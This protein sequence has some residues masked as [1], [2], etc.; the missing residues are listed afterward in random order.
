MYGAAYEALAMCGV[1]VKLN[2]EVMFDRDGNEVHDAA[3]CFGRKTRYRLLHPEDCIFV[4]EMS[5]NTNM[6]ADGIIGGTNYIV[7]N[8]GFGAAPVGLVTDMH[9]T[10]LCFASGNGEPIMCA[11]LLKSD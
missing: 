6:K 7:A 5:C 4:D 11:V 2:E 8:D 10:V 1:A 9:F 3:N